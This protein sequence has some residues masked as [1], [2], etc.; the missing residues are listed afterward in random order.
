MT[1]H[2]HTLF[3][4]DLH[5][6]AADPARCELA[7][8]FFSDAAGVSR[9]YIL[10]DFVEYWL[11]DDMGNPALSPVFDALRELASSGTSIHLMH[12]NRDFLLGHAFA[13]SI[14]ATL[15]SDDVIEFPS[16]AGSALLLHGDTL[17]TDDVDYQKLRA[18]LRSEPWQSQFL[19]LTPEERLREAQKLRDASKEALSAKDAGIMDVNEEEVQNLFRS[20]GKTLI[21]HGHTHRPAEHTVEIDGAACRRLVLGDWKPDHAQ[22]VRFDGAHF[23]LQTYR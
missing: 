17:C 19:S 14:G 20:S 6:D 5:L 12:G 4:A 16:D 21:I 3:I 9:L 8:R 23:T 7:C 2:K 13:E 15:H 18:L 11:G 1:L 22:V 10:G